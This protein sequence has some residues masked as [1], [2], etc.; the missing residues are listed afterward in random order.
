MKHTLMLVGIALA[1]GLSISGGPVV[2][3]VLVM[4]SPFAAYLMFSRAG[5]E[6]A[7]H[8][9]AVRPVPPRIQPHR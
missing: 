6:S 7:V 4:L 8:A 5:H 1:I 2:W 9:R 3:A